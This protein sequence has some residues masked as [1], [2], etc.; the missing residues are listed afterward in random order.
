MNDN[1][2]HHSSRD[3]KS[4]F[5]YCLIAA[6]IIIILFFAFK[7]KKGVPPESSTQTRQQDPRFIPAKGKIAAIKKH[8]AKHPPDAEK[9]WAE[10]GSVYASDGQFF[11]A[12]DAYQKFLALRPDAVDTWITVGLMYRKIKQPDKALTAFDKVIALQPNHE[13]ALFNKGALFLYDFKDRTLAVKAWETLLSYYPDAKA[14]N[15]VPIK[16]MV[17]QVK[18]GMSFKPS[19]PAN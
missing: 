9:W 3:K 17:S 19:S 14:P 8:L 13:I 18:I 6:L 10:L 2:R 16:D 11:E 1:E 4:L 15:G 5:M 12:L 7:D